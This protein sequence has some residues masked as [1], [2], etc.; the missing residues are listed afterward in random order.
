M[1]YQN[2]SEQFAARIP[3]RGQVNSTAP[4]L[5][6][7]RALGQLGQMLVS[8]GDGFIKAT[9]GSARID[10]IAALRAKSDA[11]LSAMGIKRDD[12]VHHV[13][14]DLYFT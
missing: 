12:I 2:A 8:L 6:A 4:F 13:F 9:E 10:R 14:R 3:A 5:T 11:E 1:I 7:R